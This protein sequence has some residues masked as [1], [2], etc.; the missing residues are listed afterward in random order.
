MPYCSSRKFSVTL[1]EIQSFVARNAGAEVHLR[2]IAGEM[3]NMEA[4]GVAALLQEPEAR[5]L[6]LRIT[7]SI[8]D[9]LMEDAHLGDDRLLRH[10]GDVYDEAVAYAAR[11]TQSPGDS[12]LPANV[13]NATARPPT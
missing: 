10:M 4:V 1:T 7:S 8:F 3:T 5:E 12:F 2:S 9:T 6:T 11:L 13:V